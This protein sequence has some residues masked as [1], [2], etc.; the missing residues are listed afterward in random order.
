[1]KHFSLLVVLI[2]LW[3]FTSANYTG[4]ITTSQNELIFTTKNGNDFVSFKGP[5]NINRVGS[6]QL[7]AKIIKV[8]IPIDQKVSSIII[9]STSVQQ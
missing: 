6:P 5:I 3:Q 7:P 2:L 4:S 1:M 8:L 9:N